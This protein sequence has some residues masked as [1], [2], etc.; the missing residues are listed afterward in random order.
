[1]SIKE[2]TI[3]AKGLTLV[4]TNDDEREYEYSAIYS[5][6]VLKNKKWY[7]LPYVFDGSNSWTTE[8][9]DLSTSK[10]SE[11]STEWDGLYGILD[12]GHYRIIKPVKAASNNDEV[13]YL[14]AEF[15]IK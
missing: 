3:T 10:S 12:K 15:D 6:E 8:A 13:Y 2:S 7:K 11:W 5:I 1:M 4:F 14:T 9:Y